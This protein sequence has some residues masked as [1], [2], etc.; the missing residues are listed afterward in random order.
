MNPETM[1]ET[2]LSLATPVIEANEICFQEAKKVAAEGRSELFVS[3]LAKSA[4]L[5]M[6]SGHKIQYGK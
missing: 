4:V 1:R 3:K 6:F 5:F 2:P